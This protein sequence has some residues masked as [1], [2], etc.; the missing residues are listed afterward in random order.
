MA[1]NLTV[2]S[3]FYVQQYWVPGRNLST[4]NRLL[5][6]PLL[7]L[8]QKGGQVTEHYFTVLSELPFLLQ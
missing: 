8:E 4:I 1:V 6:L 2:G 5:M 7:L 3:W